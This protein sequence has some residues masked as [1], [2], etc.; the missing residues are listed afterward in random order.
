MIDSDNFEKIESIFNKVCY[1]IGAIMCILVSIF[2]LYMSIMVEE[3]FFKLLLMPFPLAFT[4]AACQI[5]CAIL[6]KDKLRKI[7]SAS[8][9]VAG[10]LYWFTFLGVF[11][12]FLIIEGSYIKLCLII[13]PLYLLGF[14]IVYKAF[15]KK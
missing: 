13:V 1:S 4:F 8:Y 3:F 10:L 12:Y 6:E 14:Y 2:F 7:F 5:V 9:L 15:I 11:T